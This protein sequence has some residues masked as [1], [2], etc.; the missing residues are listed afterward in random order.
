MNKKSRMSLSK[1]NESLL[2]ANGEIYDPLNDKIISGSILIKNS[3]IEAVGQFD[4]PKNC[5]IIDCSGN[6]ITTGFTDIHAHFREP[7]REDKETLETGSMAALAGGFTEICVMPNTNPVLDT[8]ESIRFIIE[9]AAN[10]PIKI[11]PIGAITVGQNGKALAEIGEMVKAGAVAVSDD[12]LPLRNG[13]LMRYALEYSAMYGIPVIN[14]AEDI[15]LRSS[16]QIH[17][18][19]VSTRLGLSGIP[20]I[21]ES[22]MVYRDL[23]LAEFTGGRLHIPHV[24]AQKSVELI[25][26]F[27]ARGIR[28]TAEVSP[29]HLGLTDLA[30]NEFDTNTKVAPPL[31]SES[32]REALIEGLQNGTLDCI[33]T[34]HAPHTIEDKEKDFIN[35]PC[36]MIGLESA[37]GLVHTVMTS[38]GSS[39]H[40][41]LRWLSINPQR[42]LGLPA[43]TLDKGALADLVVVDPKLKWTFKRENIYSRSHNTPLLGTSFTGK[44]VLTLMGD[45][46]FTAD[47]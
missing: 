6:Y 27:K 2:L 10:L 42:A 40:D 30:A 16:G 24:S 36:G 47:V 46:L 17:E 38:A 9:K 39:T 31:R 41:V 19:R 33:A 8:P 1:I 20:D 4:Q 26:Q 13:L 22:V 18:G 7:G 23:A 5:K 14:H 3:R 21:S 15:D 34:D 43:K 35:A 28:V 11:H 44:V 29:H 45:N 32:D 37:F 25:G 12:G